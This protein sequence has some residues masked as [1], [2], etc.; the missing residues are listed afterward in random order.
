LAVSKVGLP[1]FYLLASQSPEN[2]F[3][4]PGADGA[5]KRIKK[6]TDTGASGGQTET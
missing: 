5:L 4:E 6:P 3:V 2:V 1:A